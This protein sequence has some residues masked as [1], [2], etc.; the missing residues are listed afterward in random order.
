MGLHFL[1]GRME[2]LLTMQIFGNFDSVGQGQGLG[3]AL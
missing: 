2:A 1:W 3:A